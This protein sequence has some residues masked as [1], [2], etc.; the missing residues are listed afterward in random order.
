MP[1]RPRCNLPEY[2]IFHVI[3]R[4]VARMDIVLDDLDRVWFRRQLAD[5]EERFD[6]TVHAWCLM[7]NHFHLVV[8]A[9]LEA[10][11]RGM[12]RLNFLHAQRFNRRRDR[13]GHVFQGRFAARVVEGDQALADVCD[14]VLANPVRAGLVATPDE[15]R[16]RAARC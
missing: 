9:P 3:V 2:G 15:C 14:Y 12:H 1:R 6:W 16:G 5:V 7:D 13:D 8:E 4:G 11:S 10:L